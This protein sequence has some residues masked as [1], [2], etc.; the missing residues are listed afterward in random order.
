MTNFATEATGYSPSDQVLLSLITDNWLHQRGD[1]ASERGREIK[2]Q[3]GEA[4]FPDKPDWN[5]PAYDRGTEI[6]GQAL[7]GPACPL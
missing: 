4:F 7:E 5:R 6:M 3:I 2:A 1:P